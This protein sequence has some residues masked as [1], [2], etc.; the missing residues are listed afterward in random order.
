M[1]RTY[2]YTDLLALVGSRFPRLLSDNGAAPLL[3]VVNSTIWNSADWRV[4]LAKAAPFYL[5]PLEQEYGAP[6]VSIPADFLGLRTADLVNNTTEPALRFPPMTIAK[7]LPI[8]HQQ[9]RPNAISY[10]PTTS[11][12]R[13]HPR[14]PS[15]IGAMDWQIE[16]TYKKLPVKVTSVTLN[17]T[18]PHDDIYLYVY[19]DGV[20]WI[21]SKTPQDRAAF[22]ASIRRMA[23]EEAVNLGQQFLAPA[24]PLV[25]W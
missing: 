22:D 1:A 12:W 2:T 4:S 3:D 19:L 21:M 24:N 9:D 23:D 25:G 11:A 6:N 8:T 7:W 15:G 14:P 17:G 13:I 16:A 10:E 5:A 18:L 20:T